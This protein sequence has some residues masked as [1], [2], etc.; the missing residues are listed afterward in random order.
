MELSMWSLQP[1]LPF[2]DMSG[3]EHSEDSTFVV[4]S[5]IKLNGQS[6]FSFLCY[7]LFSL[8]KMVL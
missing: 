1:F 3:T 6:I 8:K 5:M 4:G 2:S 7:A